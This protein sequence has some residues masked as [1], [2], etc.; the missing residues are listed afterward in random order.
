MSGVLLVLG[1]SL[2]I[3]ALL[4]FAMS[5]VGFL[6]Q[7]SRHR[8]TRVWSVAAG[9][10]LVLLL[11]FGTLSN[12]VSRHSGLTLT[13]EQ[14]SASNALTGLEDYDATV[15]ITR[16]VDGDTIDISPSV[17]GRSRVRLIGMDTP[18]VYF[19][20]QPY[21]PEASAFAKQQI[22]GEEVG[23]ELDVQKVDPYGR[24]LAYVYLPD[25]E[26]F[27][28]TLLEEGYA[29]VATFPP[30]VKYVDRFLEA[31]REARAAN[32][33]LWGLSAGELCEQTDRG[34]G[35]GGGC[36]GYESESQP[37]YQSDGEGSGANSVDTNLDCASFETHEEAQRVLE[38]DPSDP[39]YLD[40]DGDGEACEDLP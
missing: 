37:D 40:G 25:G 11:V 34:N 29:Q 36:S 35:I 14:S 17:E 9:A 33:G 4:A 2:A 6:I 24:L 39:N 18:E 28:E 12:A 38:E 32:R 10:S 1:V 19:G 15:T 20:T 27:N 31:Q 16:V 8:P 7:T 5:V 21:G 13:G 22:D 23:L 26:M 30:N 3:L